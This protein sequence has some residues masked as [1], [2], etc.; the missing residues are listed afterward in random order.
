MLTLNKKW[1][2]PLRISSVNQWRNCGDWGTGVQVVRKHHP[3]KIATLFCPFSKKVFFKRPFCN[4][5]NILTSG[6]LETSDRRTKICSDSEVITYVWGSELTVL[7]DHLLLPKV[8]FLLIYVTVFRKRNRFVEVLLF[9]YNKWL[10]RKLWNN[11]QKQKQP[12]K[13]VPWK[14]PFLNFNRLTKLLKKY[15]RRKLFVGKI[16]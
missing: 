4:E 8:F 5:G 2:F 15:L 14:Q 10:L 6:I 12:L 13:E 1:S 9:C 16:L 3:D 11:K 7:L